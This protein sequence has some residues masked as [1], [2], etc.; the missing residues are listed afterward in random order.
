MCGFPSRRTVAGKPVTDFCAH[1]SDLK[2]QDNLHRWH[3]TIETSVNKL[4]RRTPRLKLNPEQYRLLHK[5]VLT[6]DSWRC[7]ACGSARNLQI[8]HIQPRSKLGDDSLQ[9]LITLCVDCHKA[10][11]ERSHAARASIGLW[12]VLK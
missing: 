6:R 8:H 3:S 2:Q 4:Q 11:H 10:A 7:Q 1:Q 9:N 12:R 5:E